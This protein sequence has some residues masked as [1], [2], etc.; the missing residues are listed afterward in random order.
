[1]EDDYNLFMN[2]LMKTK[3]MVDIPINSYAHVPEIRQAFNAGSY[4]RAIMLLSC[5][6]ESTLNNLVLLEVIQTNKLLAWERADLQRFSLQTLIDWVSGIKIKRKRWLKLDYGKYPPIITTP[7]ISPE[8][9]V[10]LEKLK[11]IR[12]DIA[13]CSYLTYDKNLRKEL[14]EEIINQTEPIYN[15]L[16]EELIRLSKLRHSES[17]LNKDYCT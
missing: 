5:T 17:D 8:E 7:L 13:H 2:T 6:V 10:V 16:V 12:N 3:I 15:K 1:M 14:I 11:D 4:F 9:K